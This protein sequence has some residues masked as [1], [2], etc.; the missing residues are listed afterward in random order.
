MNAQLF[1]TDDQPHRA[2]PLA[3]R[4]RPRTLAEVVGQ[5]DLLG[6]RGPLRLLLEDDS[7]PSILL[8]GPPGCGKT[9]LARLAA[10]HTRARFLEYSAVAVG[11]KELKAVMAESA[12][13]L[14]ATGQRTILFLDE[15]HRFNKA[16]QDAL[17]PWV[18]RG[19]VTL[20]GATTENPSFE[21]NSALISRTRLFVLAVLGP[22]AVAEL[23]ARALVD[24]RGLAGGLKLADDAIEALAIAS[25]GDARQALGLLETLAA[26]VTA[27]AVPGAPEKPVTREMLAGALG[28]RAARFDK[29]GDEHFNV[30]S[31]LH[32]SLRNSDVQAS[33]YWLGRQLAGG[34]D[35]LYVARRLVRFASE[36]V[37]LADPLA[38]AQ[39][40]AARDAVHFLGRPEGDLALA[41]AVVYLALAPKSNAIY[42][43]AKAVQ[44]EVARGANPPVPLQ[45]RNAPTRLMK[46]LD[47]GRGY[48]YAPDTAAGIASM[49]CLPD[50]LQGR[51]FYEPGRWGHET[52][53]AER[54]DGIRRWHERQRNRRDVTEGEEPRE[55][56]TP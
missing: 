16:Q 29:G 26:A 9:T 32:K 34:Q 46:E 15:I 30:I 36:D 19:D 27:G 54:M 18:E 6:T 56:E 53:L 51:V 3:D 37:G 2:A 28:T 13:L 8:W 20:I 33:L 14:Q 10:S 52:E 21:V 44:R 24:E 7:L 50:A 23:L 25:E 17:L 43:A 22:G 5:D 40:L 45:L 55:G 4:M 31:A 39:T 42:R 35:P 11:S 47:H 38:L 12:R 48:L 41:Q 49:D 1:P